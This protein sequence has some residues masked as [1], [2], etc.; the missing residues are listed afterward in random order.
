MRIHLKDFLDPTELLIGVD[1]AGKLMTRGLEILKSRLRTMGI[2]LGWTVLDRT[3]VYR[4]QTENLA[5]T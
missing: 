5:V 4:E 1:V 2:K 3:K